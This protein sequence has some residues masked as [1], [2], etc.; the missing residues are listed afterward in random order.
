MIH[1]NNNQVSERDSGIKARMAGCYRAL[2]SEMSSELGLVC[3]SLTTD[4][5]AVLTEENARIVDADV[6]T[7]RESKVQSR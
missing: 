5:E 2:S 3:L 7:R 6:Q 1:Y 4:R